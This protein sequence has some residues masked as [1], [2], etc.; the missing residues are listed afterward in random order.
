MYLLSGIHS[1]FSNSSMSG[2]L[3]SSCL[4]QREGGYPYMFGD[5]LGSGGYSRVPAA[6]QQHPAYTQPQ[7]GAGT[8]EFYFI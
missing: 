2:G 4:Q 8:G 3:S 1:A 5:V 7:G 6:H